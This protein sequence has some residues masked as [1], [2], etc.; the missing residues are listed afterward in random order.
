MFGGET[1]TGML[2]ARRGQMVK[3]ERKERKKR[4]KLRKRNGDREEKGAEWACLRD[5]LYKIT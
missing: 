4:E 3:K 1:N 2:F 5:L